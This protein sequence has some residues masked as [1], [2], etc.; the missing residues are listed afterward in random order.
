MNRKGMSESLEIE[1]KKFK[2][3]GYKIF[4]L[5]DNKNNFCKFKFEKSSKKE[6]IK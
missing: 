2:E 1:L 4:N 6:R 5:S 3:K